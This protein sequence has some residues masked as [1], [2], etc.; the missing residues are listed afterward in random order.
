M[1]PDAELCGEIPC[2]EYRDKLECRVQSLENENLTLKLAEQGWKTAL[3]E[4]VD[5]LENVDRHVG[6]LGGEHGKLERARK[7]LGREAPKTT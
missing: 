4:M 6:L 3:N 7:L 5:A 1:N 2:A